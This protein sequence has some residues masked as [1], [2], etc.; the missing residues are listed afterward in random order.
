MKLFEGNLK[1][2][3]WVKGKFCNGEFIY[4]YIKMIDL[5]KKVVLINVVKS[6]DEK[7][8]GII[9]GMMDEKIE[10]LFF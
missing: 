8:V 6:D 7:M 2:G 5:F 9:I 10:K 3:D 4:G 1:V